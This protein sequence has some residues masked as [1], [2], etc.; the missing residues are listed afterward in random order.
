MPIVTLQVGFLFYNIFLVL[1]CVKEETVSSKNF[2]SN[3]NNLETH[4]P[5][6]VMN[7]IRSMEALSADSC[8]RRPMFQ[9][10]V[11]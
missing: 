2:N 4:F 8:F 5:I 10:D 11:L 1:C 9:C 6:V 3:S 7:L